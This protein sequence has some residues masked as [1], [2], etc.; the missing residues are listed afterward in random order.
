MKGSFTFPYNISGGHD[1][2][3]PKIEHNSSPS[4]NKLYIK[5]YMDVTGRGVVRSARR[6][7]QGPVMRVL[8]PVKVPELAKNLK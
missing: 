8:H 1:T 2:P 6:N 4:E 7:S 5:L 3:F